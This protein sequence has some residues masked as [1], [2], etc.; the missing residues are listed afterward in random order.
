MTPE[1]K[2]RIRTKDIFFHPWVQDFEKEFKQEKIE[3]MQKEEAEKNKKNE[4]I[5]LNNNNGNKNSKLVNDLLNDKDEVEFSV[6]VNNKITE[7]VKMYDSGKNN[8]KP[9]VILLDKQSKALDF[10]EG[11][12]KDTIKENLNKKKD[13]FS[14]L[15]KEINNDKKNKIS[16]E[17]DNSIKINTNKEVNHYNNIGIYSASTKSDNSIPNNVS[18]PKKET[19]NDLLYTKTTNSKKVNEIAE[20]SILDNNQD[21]LFDKVL[22]QVEKKNKDKKRKRTNTSKLVDSMNDSKYNVNNKS[23]VQE[24]TNLKFF[25][26]EEMNKMNLSNAYGSNKK[27]DED[28]FDEE[29]TTNKKKELSK[30]KPSNAFLESEI[31]ESTKKSSNNTKSNEFNLINEE[32]TKYTQPN[33]KKKIEINKPN[34]SFSSKN[35]KKLNKSDN[36]IK[37]LNKE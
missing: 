30:L 1:N 8:P 7:K 34:E 14:L 5:V 33:N 26:E 21:N 31:L 12:E 20:F 3:K 16:A 19:T 32:E 35:E 4:E 13:S 15:E 9:G 37:D 17:D 2:N 27:I 28:I 36:K 25:L 24:S 29:Y 22:S 6:K 18:L 10:K 23:T 11:E